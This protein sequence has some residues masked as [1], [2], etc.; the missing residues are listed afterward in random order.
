[1]DGDV[2]RVPLRALG[3]IEQSAGVRLIYWIAGGGEEQISVAKWQL[4]NACVTTG[5]L[6]HGILVIRT[7]GGAAVTRC[8][9]GESLRKRPAVGEV[10]YASP[11]AKARWMGEGTSEALHIY[12]PAARVRR[13]AEE[14][15]DGPSTPRIDDLFAVA[16]PWLQGYAQM[17]TSEIEI[18]HQ[19]GGSADP[20]FLA[21]TEHL[22]LRHLLTW[23][24]DA[25]ASAREAPE[26][27][28]SGNALPASVLRRVQSYID[29]NLAD[30]IRLRDLADVA[31]MSSGHFLRG[32]RVSSG[33]TPYHYVLELRLQ[34]ACSMLR[35][36]LEPVSR[37]AVECGFK[38]LSHLS[39]RFHGRFGVSPSRF[40]AAQRHS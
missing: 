24:S 13:F 26:R 8:M 27:R 2:S 10:T 29:A 19:G 1:M 33:T 23:H 30:E 28:K 38:T 22:L 37:V 11:D 20:L 5:D 18:F 15:L 7:G 25:S 12:L 31:C 9:R 35:S 16:D 36:G 40:R 34:R 32:F 3:R 4:D 17:L 14:E 6:P 21:Q 39:A